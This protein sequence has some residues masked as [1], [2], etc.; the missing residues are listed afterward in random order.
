MQLEPT[1][2]SHTLMENSENTRPVVWCISASDSAGHAGM[3]VDIT[4][5]HQLG[6]HP[7]S[8]L[9]AV[10][11]QN[12]KAVS[13]VSPISL[14]DFLA[15][16]QSLQKDIP[17]K[18]IKIGLLGDADQVDVLEETLPELEAFRILDPVMVA[19]SG[20]TLA[21]LSAIDQ[22]KRLLPVVD[23]VT[24]NLDE[25]AALSG[26][27]IQSNEDI[28]RAA[29]CIHDMGAPC[30]LIKGG[31][32]AL[33]SEHCHD[34]LSICESWTG[35][36]PIRAWLTQPRM[37]VQN[38][39]GTG[40]TMASAIATLVAQGQ[41]VQDAATIASAYIHQGLKSGY[42]V[43]TG[44][45]PISKGAFPEVFSHYPQIHDHHP[46]DTYVPKPDG[47]LFSDHPFADCGTSE[48]GL[49]PVVD[50][51]EWLRILAPM[52]ISTLQ[53]RVKDVAPEAL[54]ALV[55]EAVSITQPYGIRLFINDYW[56]LAIKH[57]AYGVHLGQEDLY[58]ADLSAIKTAGIRLGVSTH[59]EFEWA[60]AATLKPSYIAI[61]AIFPTD[62]KEVQVVGM[63]NLNRWVKILKSHFPLTAIGGINLRNLDSVLQTGV[64]S[65]AVVSAITKS[66]SVIKAVSQFMHQLG[67]K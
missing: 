50:S 25:A 62:T 32:G 21:M 49:Y 43:G 37:D 35:S 44:A 36:S 19:S 15:Q 22:L 48:L 9:T 27:I 39:R 58:E 47:R 34:Y 42:Q 51:L 7:C 64:K 60:R 14:S 28:Q 3:Q 12:S 8:I 59:G 55:K 18:A 66:P 31:H 41:N 20:D 45:G 16:L 26:L 17:A 30:V 29:Q 2:S 40:C 46:S 5:V 61:G 56:Q 1:P 4:A 33:E 13:K 52:G 53:L 65:V 57:H 54:D 67:S 23:M 6:G 11:A 63:E 24:P 38:S 10:T